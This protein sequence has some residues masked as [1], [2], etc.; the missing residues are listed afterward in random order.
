MPSG[1][2]FPLHRG[3]Q[4]A[5]LRPSASVFLQ[6]LR[7]LSPGTCSGRGAQEYCA[8]GGQGQGC[9]DVPQGCTC[10]RREATQGAQQTLS[11]RAGAWGTRR[12]SP[13]P[14][15]PHAALPRHSPAPCVHCSCS[16]ERR[17]G[18]PPTRWDE[19]GNHWPRCGCPSL[20]Q[21]RGQRLA[22]LTVVWGGSDREPH[23]ID[24]SVASPD[25]SGPSD[26]SL[27]L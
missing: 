24:S 8:P 11:W 2:G 27:P 5:C 1:R 3:R 14:S 12:V 25:S 17:G 20:A 26:P 4:R 18:F 9:P 15:R 23:H 22:L 13:H 21:P 10:T 16:L 19:K 7:R 6:W